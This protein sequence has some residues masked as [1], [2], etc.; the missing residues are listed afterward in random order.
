MNR[1]YACMQDRL[2]ANSVPY[3]APK[4]V[5]DFGDCWLWIGKTFKRGYGRLN[6]RVQGHVKTRLAHREAWLAFNG[7]LANDET[8]NHKCLILRCINPGHLEPMSRADNS[9]EMRARVCSNK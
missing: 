6:V 9:R 2:L 4:S 8:L 5:A 7:A 3:P 1:K